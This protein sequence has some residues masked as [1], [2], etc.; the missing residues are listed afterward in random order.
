M[1]LQIFRVFRN[2]NAEDLLFSRVRSGGLDDDID[3]CVV[4]AKTQIAFLFFDDDC[5]LTVRRRLA[6]N[7]IHAFAR[8]NQP[9][10]SKR[11]LTSC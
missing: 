7:G 8:E 10:V 4:Q 9:N 11:C 3:K 6:E 2:L 5:L 1:Y